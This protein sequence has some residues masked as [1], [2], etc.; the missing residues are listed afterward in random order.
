MGLFSFL[1][2]DKKTE[3]NT[4]ST[5]LGMVLLEAPNSFDLTGTVNELK[6]KWKLKVNDNDPNDK[7]AVLAIGD[8]SVAVANIPAPIPKEEVEKQLNTI[9]SGKT[10]LKKHPNTKDILFYQL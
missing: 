8:Y 10:E 3:S 6:T 9:I 4:N 5:I 2:K 7:A 1:K